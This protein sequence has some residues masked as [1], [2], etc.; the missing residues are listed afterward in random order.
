MCKSAPGT[1]C[2]MVKVHAENGRLLLVLRDAHH[3]VV[4]CVRVHQSNMYIAV[5]SAKGAR[6]KWSAPSSLCSCGIAL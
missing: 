5:H 1:V 2:T 4:R 3:C 6:W